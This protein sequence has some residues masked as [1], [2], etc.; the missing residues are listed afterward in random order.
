MNRWLFSAVMLAAASSLLPAIDPCVS[1][2][3]VGQ[4]PGPYTFIV[5]T[6]KERGQL[7]C[8]IC[9]TGDK[10]AFVIFAR[11]PTDE[12]GKLT[13]E[14]DRFAGEPKN[15]PV[16]GWVTFLSNDQTKLD[17]EV[18]AWGKKHAVQS[19]PLGVFEDADGPPSY[20]LASDADVTVLF[21]VKQK[22][23]ANF[24]YRKGELNEAARK[25]ILKAAPKLLENK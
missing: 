16:R 19:L 10:P 7:T 5:S 25:E 24:A 11:T 6:G 15:A 22:V 1:G 17:P 13:H 20:R 9:E 2:V 3:Q 8:Y 4:R 14:L 12:L 18:I 23:I 21:F